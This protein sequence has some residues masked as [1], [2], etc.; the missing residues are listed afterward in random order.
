[1]E[2]RNNVNIGRTRKFR[3]YK[4]SKVPNKINMI[5]NDIRDQHPSEYKVNKLNKAKWNCNRNTALK[6]STV[7]LFQ[8]HKNSLADVQKKPQLH[9][10]AHYGTKRNSKQN[11]DRHK[12][13]AKE[14]NNQSSFSNGNDQTS[15]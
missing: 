2:V 8:V 15:T 4:N 13:H 10:I 1:M 14:K 11:H 9:N 6:R 5:R 12:P 7:K 3:N